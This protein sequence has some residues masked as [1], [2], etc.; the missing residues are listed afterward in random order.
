MREGLKIVPWRPL[1]FAVNRFANSSF[2][3]R[4]IL[5]S[6]RSNLTVLS[7]HVKREPFQFIS[8]AHI[9]ISW[10]L[11]TWSVLL[12]Y[13]SL[14][15]CS[16]LISLGQCLLDRAYNFNL[17]SRWRRPQVSLIPVK[18]LIQNWLHIELR[19]LNGSFL[20]LHYPIREFVQHQRVHVHM[21]FCWARRHGLLNSIH[22]FR[23]VQHR[24]IFAFCLILM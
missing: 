21:V 24:A 22:V 1:S 5:S 11:N 10:K 17:V 20:V 3:L 13:V 2:C 12:I 9:V 18:L 23:S 6:I 19:F 16:L 14:F 4:S 7:Q 15:K 8:R